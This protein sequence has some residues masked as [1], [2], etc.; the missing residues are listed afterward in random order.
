MAKA[1]GLTLAIA[2][3]SDNVTVE[4]KLAQNLLLNRK[5]ASLEFIARYSQLASAKDKPKA[6]GLKRQVYEAILSGN[7]ENIVKIIKQALKYHIAPFVLV[8][9][10]MIPAIIKAGE[11]FEKKQYFL[12]QLIA[13]AQAMKQGLK[14]LQPLLKSERITKGKKAAI[15]LATVEGDVHDI[16]KNI[17]A[18]L[19]ENHGFEIVDLGKD[20]SAQKIIHEIKR[21]QPDIVGLS[22]LMTTTMV[23]MKETITLARKQGLRCKFMVGGAVLNRDY[24]DSI[25]ASFAKDG[26][27]AA[28]LAEKLVKKA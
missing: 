17:V 1:K 4:N 2:N 14:F 21:Y 19:L 3:P 28:R 23:N 22:A 12:P 6:H 24:A 20:V 18:L 11:L 16:G 27:E 9:K 26:V 8:E 7:K 13:S 5:N 10:Y 15:M 25:G